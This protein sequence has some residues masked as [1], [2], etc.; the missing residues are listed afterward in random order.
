MFTS[1]M[2]PKPASDPV[3][4]AK[5]NFTALAL[6]ILDLPRESVESVLRQTIASVSLLSRP[7]YEQGE[8]IQ[9]LPLRKRPG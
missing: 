3:R 4:R 6:D 9:N 1:Q 5:I 8:L 2:S 7:E